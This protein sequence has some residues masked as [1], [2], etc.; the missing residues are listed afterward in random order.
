[1]AALLYASA[2]GAQTDSASRAQTDSAGWVKMDPLGTIK[3]QPTSIESKGAT[4]SAWFN[5]WQSANDT[6]SNGAHASYHLYHAVVNCR[7]NQIATRASYFYNSAGNVVKS[8]DYS[9]LPV[10]HDD[11]YEAAPGS[12]GEQLI[13]HLCK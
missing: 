5:I 3:V 11:W 8:E 9:Q 7:T 13:R 10:G 6:L 2:A 4:K 1:V 12:V